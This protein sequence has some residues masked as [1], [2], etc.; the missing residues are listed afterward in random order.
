[1]HSI[2]THSCLAK[3][4]GVCSNLS[5][6]FYT[7]TVQLKLILDRLALSNLEWHFSAIG[8][9]NVRGLSSGGGSQPGAAYQR[10]DQRAAFLTVEI[11]FPRPAEDN[12]KVTFGSR[13]V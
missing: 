2:F 8:D 1:M 6:C 5:K 10:K 11:E 3:Y 12:A 4:V 9:S 7:I 13:I